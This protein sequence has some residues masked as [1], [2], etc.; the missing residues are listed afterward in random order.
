MCLHE[1][2][3]VH[4]G[5]RGGDLDIRLGEREGDVRDFLPLGEGFLSISLI[6]VS[7]F[8]S[9][10][11]FVCISDRIMFFRRFF[12]FEAFCCGLDRTKDGE[13]VEFFSIMLSKSWTLCNLL[14]GLDFTPSSSILSCSFLSKE[15]SCRNSSMIWDSLSA[16]VN[17]LKV[18]SNVSLKGK[19]VCFGSKREDLVGLKRKFSMCCDF[20]REMKIFSIQRKIE[21]LIMS[22]IL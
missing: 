10:E 13:V 1:Q 4:L 2:E 22:S 9:W 18:T 7:I 5:E 11:R 6:R 21:D 12:V 16:E 20:I 14:R 3:F 15:M 8:S 19:V 17:P